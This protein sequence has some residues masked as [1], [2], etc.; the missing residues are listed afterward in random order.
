MHPSWKALI[1]L[2][3]VYVCV[4]W[5]ELSLLN[6]VICI[7]TPH[8]KINLRAL[9][10]KW[11]IMLMSSLSGG[12]CIIVRSK[13]YSSFVQD[14]LIFR[15]TSVCEIWVSS[16]S[17]FFSKFSRAGNRWLIGPTFIMII[18]MLPLR[19]LSPPAVIQTKLSSALLMGTLASLP[20]SH[21][22]VIQEVLVFIQWTKVVL[23]SPWVTL[24]SNFWAFS[25]TQK[26]NIRVFSS[27]HLSQRKKKL[28]NF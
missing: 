5:I 21:N 12:K 8:N 25:S 13:N 15:L 14:S 16:H 27:R 17:H 23:K 7:V 4:C 9:H 2:L 19:Y 10:N 1:C 20:T 6:K 3:C 18:S 22:L 28:K 24:I 11:H 26:G